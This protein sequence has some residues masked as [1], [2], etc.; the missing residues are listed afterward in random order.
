M[1]ESIFIYLLFGRFNKKYSE[2]FSEKIKDLTFGQFPLL[3]IEKPD[4]VSPKNICSY[5]WFY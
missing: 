3:E 1:I 4:I 2:L 5:N